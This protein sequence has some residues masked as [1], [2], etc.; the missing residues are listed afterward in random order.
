MYSVV[1]DDF[2]I[3]TLSYYQKRKKELQSQMRISYS[4]LQQNKED[5]L[6]GVIY[7]PQSL[8]DELVIQDQEKEWI[9]I[10]QIYEHFRRLSTEQLRDMNVFLRSIVEEQ[11]S[12]NRIMAAYEMLD[13]TEKDILKIMYMEEPSRKLQVSVNLLM[14]KYSCSSRTIYRARRAALDHIHDI[15]NSD[16][17]QSEIYRLV[18]GKNNSD[19]LD[20]NSYR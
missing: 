9:D 3:N 11:E 19:C 17:T 16:L 18:P 1:T 10:S 8:A 6:S 15:Y 7:P 2:I 20:K 14:K 13:S 12:M 4:Q 5:A